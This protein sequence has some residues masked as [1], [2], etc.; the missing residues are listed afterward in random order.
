MR[1]LANIFLGNIHT[2][3][4][5]EVLYKITFLFWEY[6]RL[7]LLW[8]WLVFQGQMTRLFVEIYFTFEECDI[9]I[10]IKLQVKPF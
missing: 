6:G 5:V 7:R 2:S 9:S 1:I 3:D 4:S 10:A 8:A